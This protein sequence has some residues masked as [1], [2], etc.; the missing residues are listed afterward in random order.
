M[1]F[2]M[3]PFPPEELILVQPPGQWVKWGI[4]APD[5]VWKL[6]RAVYGLRQSP[7]WWADERDSN[8]RKLTWKVDGEEYYLEQNE[9][10]TQVWSLKQRKHPHRLLG[11]LCVYVDDFLLL[12]EKSTSRDEFVQTLESSPLRSP[13]PS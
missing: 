12:A 7:K 6:N 9:A 11:L 10:D 5:V 1:L 8:L 13:S 3:H 4:V 2:L